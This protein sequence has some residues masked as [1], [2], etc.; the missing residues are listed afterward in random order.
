VF[1][2]NVRGE[3]VTRFSADDSLGGKMSRAQRMFFKLNGLTWW[4]DT[5]RST[6][7]LMMSHHLAYNR[8]LGW[9]KM[10]PDLQ[11]TLSLFDI[12]AGKWE[13]L[14]NTPSRQADGR[15]YLTTQGIDDIPAADL[16]AYLTQ[17]GR[18]VNAQAVA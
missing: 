3:V 8:A 13:L 16:E 2:D 5:M 12:D 17:R 6:A 10:N 15:E 7:A 9:D 11:R 4:T 18:P 14:R 1:F